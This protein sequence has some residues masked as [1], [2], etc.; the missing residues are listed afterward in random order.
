M[1]PVARELLGEPNKGLSTATELRWG[2]RGSI[3]VNLAQGVYED[4][5]AGGKGGL[6][7]FIQDVRKCDKQGAV[8]WLKER[9]HLNDDQH[10]K[11]AAPGPIVATYDY[12]NSDG[13]LL[14][15]VTRHNPK[16]FRQ[17]QPDGRGGWNWKMAGVQ[18]VPYKLPDLLDAIE[19]GETVFITNGEKATEAAIKLGIAATNLPAGEGKWH[20]HYAPWFNGAHVVVLPDNDDTGAEHARRVAAGL[21]AAARSMRVLNL[22][23]LPPKGDLFDW[24][25]A[26]GTAEGL[27]ALADAVQPAAK[28]AELAAYLS[29]EAWAEREFPA[30]VR[31]LG[32]L[33]TKTSRVFLVGQTGLGKTLLG[34]EIGA[35]MATGTGFLD[36]ACDRPVRV[37]Y[38]DGEMPGELIKA[39]IRDTMRRLGRSDLAGNLFFYSADMAEKIAAI[40]PALGEMQPLNTEAGQNFIYALI[41]ALGGVDVVIFDNV[42]SLVAGDQK[43]EVPW[44]ETLPLISGLTRKQIGQVWLDHTGHNTA[45]QYGSSTKAWRFDAVGIMTALP[46]EDRQ[47]GETAFQLSFEAPGKARRRTSNN[48]ADF[49]TRIIRLR[50]DRWISETAGSA[51]R[52]DVAKVSPSREAF[53]APLLSAITKSCSGPGTATLDEWEAECVRT[54]LIEAAEANETGKERAAR[55]ANLRVAQ[56][57]LISAKWIAVDKP[58]ARDL[59]NRYL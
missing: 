5:E 35:G 9:G 52:R 56:G 33:V 23:K 34:V 4:H 39:R 41:D 45:R 7:D 22:P 42:M 46:E 32:D 19:A 30:P 12:L 17:R 40:F 24:V 59:R 29:A 50:D 48:W 47:E 58:F 54:G 3:R 1:G 55:K 16:D 49:A 37:L 38:V 11:P 14:F 53:Y 25:A 51:V 26:G 43:E 6:L 28:P 2:T 13:K 31:L 44:S 8:A 15:Q 27:I 10:N 20:D 21:A 18:L 36:W 57:V